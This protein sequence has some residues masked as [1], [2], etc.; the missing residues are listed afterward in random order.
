M[1]QVLLL[2]FL[3][4]SLIR[5]IIQIL[6]FILNVILLPPKPVI[7]L[8]TLMSYKVLSKLRSPQPNSII[9]NLLMHNIPLH[10][11]SK[12]ITKSLSRLSSSELL[13]LQK[14]LSKKY[15]RP[16]K[17]M[18]QPG[19]LSF[20]LYLLESMHSV[21]LV[22]YVFIL[23]LTISNSFSKRIQLAS[24]LVIIN[25]KPEYEISWIVDSKIDY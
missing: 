19:I 15:L 21:H 2:I 14:K 3:Y 5:D 13:G 24:V 16:Y 20:T 18:V 11:I 7:L 17:I 23:E 6:L 4:S 22:F 12:Q 9:R 1:L 10:L 25:R 8:Q